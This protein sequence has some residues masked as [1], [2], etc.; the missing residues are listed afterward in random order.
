[1]AVS[2]LWQLMTVLPRMYTFVRPTV[3]P[4]LP[5][6]SLLN[7]AGGSREVAIYHYSRLGY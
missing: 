4:F 2:Y 5:F 6:S 7:A 3:P 1:M